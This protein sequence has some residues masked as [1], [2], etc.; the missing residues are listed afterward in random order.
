M[1]GSFQQTG[2]RVSIG[3]ALLCLAHCLLLPLMVLALP[4]L[5]TSFLKQEAF[6]QMLLVGVLLTSVL[7]L[8]S[9]CKTHRKWQIFGGGIVGLVV[10]SIAALF[11]HDWFGEFGESILTVIGSLI[12]AY[13][14]LI[15]IKTCKS[16]SCHN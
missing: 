12:V 10:L 3:L 15:N 5:A 1:L 7:A 11:G 2:D 9:G 6:H 14:H 13:S 4:F 8:Y 16:A